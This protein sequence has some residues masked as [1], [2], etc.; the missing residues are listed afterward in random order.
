MALLDS[1]ARSTLVGV[2]IGAGAMLLL[3]YTIPVVSAVAR[4]FCKAV[5][6]ASMEGFEK[7]SHQLAVAAEAFQDLVAEARAERTL[8]PA[9]AS[10][11][12]V[13]SGGSREVN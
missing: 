11:D 13:M 3:R 1:Q 2:G 8:D 10:G 7:A 5:I 6:A 9:A 12:A 4:P